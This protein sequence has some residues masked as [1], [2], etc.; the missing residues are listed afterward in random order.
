MMMNV[1]DEN[2]DAPRRRTSRIDNGRHVHN[3]RAAAGAGRVCEPGHSC[4]ANCKPFEFNRPR[5]PRSPRCQA[6]P[7]AQHVNAAEPASASPCRPDASPNE[8]SILLDPD[9]RSNL[10]IAVIT[11]GDG[12]GT[13]TPTGER[14]SPLLF[15]GNYANGD[16]KSLNSYRLYATNTPRKRS[17]ATM[18]AQSIRSV[19]THAPSP[20]A[21]EDNKK[22]TNIMGFIYLLVLLID[23][24]RY[25]ST[26]L[27]NQKI[28]AKHEEKLEEMYRKHEMEFGPSTPG[29]RTPESKITMAPPPV[30]MPLRHNYCFS[31]GRHAGS[32]YLKMGATGFAF[33]HLVHSILLLAVQINFLLDENIVNDECVD[34]VQ[35]ALDVFYPLYSFF[36][37]YFIFKYSNVIILRWQALAR[38]GFMHY[39]GSSLCFWVWVIVR[40]TLLAL[41]MYAQSQYGNNTYGSSEAHVQTYK[42]SIPGNR[43]FDVSGLYNENCIGSSTVTAIFQNVSPYLYPFSV[44]F[45]ILIVGIFYIIWHNIGECEKETDDNDDNYTNSSL[46]ETNTLCKIPTAS[47]ENDYTSNFVIHAD[48]HASNRGLFAGL[49]VTIILIGMLIIGFIFS[50]VGEEFME[51]GYLLND[52]TKL[53]LHSLMLLT[54]VVAYNQTRKLD[55]NQHPISLLDDI[56]LFVC[57][58]AFFMETVFT[59]VATVS[60]VNVI[61]FLDV[62]IMSLQVIIQTAFLVDGLRRCSNSRKLRRTKPG[63][64]LLMFLLIANVAM[65]IFNTFSYKSPESLDE[66]YTFYGKVLWSILGHIT[67]PLIMFYRFHSSVCFADI[68]DSAYKPGSEH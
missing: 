63:R 29:D 40:E 34:V 37:L 59:M 18:D 56:L 20:T 46:D 66:R 5:V 52:C 55:I 25:K 4:A 13:A 8:I 43:I 67:L 3:G 61:K 12:S 2:D 32:F 65:W 6:G 64:E 41:T 17:M 68:W 21:L 33:G 39:I 15:G 22:L 23:I 19:E 53:A 51:L 35:V 1:D 62:T 24:G 14:N 11:K 30:L 27:K 36:Q 44:E 9:D 26:A 48:C 38:F 45:N 50:S 7:S 58:P 49:I 42:R 10:R 31:T 16:M 60:I 28:K 47:E 57:L 54:V